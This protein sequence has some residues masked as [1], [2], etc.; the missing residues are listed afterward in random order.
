MINHAIILPLK[1]NFGKVNAGAVSIWVSSYLKYSKLN[2]SISIF[3]SKSNKPYLYNKNLNFIDLKE[4]RILTNYSYIKAIANKLLNK[5]IHS[6]EIHN[7]PEYAKYLIKNTNIKI[8]LIF[9]NDPS[10]LRDSNTIEKREYLL[11]NCNKIIFVSKYLKNKFFTNLDSKHKN[12][13]EVIYNSINKLKKFPKKNNQIIF[14]GKLNKSKGY[15]I[16]GKAIIKILSKYKNWNALVIGNEPREKY[17]FKHP[18]LKILDWKEHNKILKY[19]E[20]SSISVVNPTWQEPFGRTAMESASRGCAVITSLSGGLQETFKNNIILKKNDEKN[21]YKCLEKLIIDKKKLKRIQKYNFKNVLHDIKGVSKVIDDTIPVKNTNY[22][23]KKNL[24]ILH[25]STFGEKLNH[26]NFNLS[27]AKKISN[28]FIRNGHDVIDFD[29][30]NNKNIF[31]KNS[32]GDK[33]FE[34]SEN[35]KPNLIL[36]GHNNILSAESF[37]KVKKNCD[38]KFALWYEDHLVKGDPSYNENL[39]LIENNN[40]LIDTYFVT[41]HTSEIKT[42]IDK[43]KLFF[44]P[45]PVDENIEFGKFYNSKKSKDLFFALS[46]G[47]N[48]GKLKKDNFDER[49]N[50]IKKLVQISNNNI[51]FNILGLFNEDPKWNFNYLKEL[52]LSK[53]ALNLSRGGPSKYA[54]S[55]RFATLMGN[56][57]ATFIDEKIKYQDFF[58]D[59]ELITYRNISDLCNK[60]SKLCNNDK[61]LFKIGKNAKKRYFDIFSNKIISDYIISQ[62]FNTKKS[63]NYAWDK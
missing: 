25:I 51:N 36:L 33:I 11:K 3:A 14:S 12:N 8:N 40:H 57:V 52:E 54:T 1:E 6:V 61:L 10:S 38:T 60:L 50:F 48:F 43:K 22:I 35:Y 42:V 5:K 56:G 21:L 23:K 34:I 9:H 29:Y 2:K 59:K 39:S 20:T 63:F 30:R 18:R 44:I 41:T 16:F 7:R 45:V 17:Y 46:H 58:S 26:R 15:N 31:S 62:T 53:T 32:I 47:V 55:N 24:R 4:K 19:Y 27:I 13:T 49:D 28:G 37:E